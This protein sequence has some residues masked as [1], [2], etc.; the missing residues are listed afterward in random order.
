[1][2]IITLLTVA[3]LV[4]G[5]SGGGSPQRP[6]LPDFPG[7]NASISDQQ[8]SLVFAYPA[9]GQTD[10]VPTAPIVL[11]FSH[12]VAALPAG[13]TLKSLFTVKAKTAATGVDF[14]I[15][16]VDDGLGVVIQP[17]LPLSDKTEYQIIAPQIPLALENPGAIGNISLQ[18]PGSPVLS[19]TT[20]AA[21]EG[22]MICR[23]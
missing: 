16:L 7:P 19:F 2:R 8:R 20:R 23:R 14:D 15:K 3:A 9:L 5:C 11:R 4:A 21:F 6:V 22:P 10:V 17:T 13:T 12:P 18:P 1:M